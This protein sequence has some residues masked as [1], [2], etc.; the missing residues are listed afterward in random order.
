MQA[1]VACTTEVL[2]YRA[3]NCGER[4]NDWM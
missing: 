1:A 4:M 3:Q 2:L